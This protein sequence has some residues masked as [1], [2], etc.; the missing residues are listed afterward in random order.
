MFFYSTGFWLL[1]G[2]RSLVDSRWS[3]VVGR[4]QTVNYPHF[5]GRV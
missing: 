5:Y 4:L 1:V 3:L 2:D